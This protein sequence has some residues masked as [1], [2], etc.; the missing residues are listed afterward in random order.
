MSRDQ[1]LLFVAKTPLGFTVRVTRAY[2]D[3]ISTLKH[4]VMRGHLDEVRAA[5]E[6]PDEIRLSKTD[7]QVYLF[8]KIQR[9]ERWVCAVSRRRGSEGFLITAYPTDAIKEGEQIWPI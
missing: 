5:L 8:Y 7:D 2:W 4:P 3:I 1:D 9:P 6:S